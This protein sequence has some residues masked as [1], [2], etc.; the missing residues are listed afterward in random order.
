MQLRGALRFDEVTRSPSQ[1]ASNSL[2]PPRPDAAPTSP[3]R[4]DSMLEGSGGGSAVHD[5]RGGGFNDTRDVGGVLT[6][7][8]L[9]SV[10]GLVGERYGSAT[11]VTSL[12]RSHVDLTQM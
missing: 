6:G 3:I 7:Q 10:S 9:K 5:H 8:S 11:H 1:R 2:F 12:A 4:R